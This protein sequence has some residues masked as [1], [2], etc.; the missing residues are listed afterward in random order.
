MP[1][2]SLR[3]FVAALERAGELRRIA[4]PVNVDL[5]ITEI[6]D[7][8]VKS[9][10]PA[11]LFENPVGP[12]GRAFDIPVLINAYAS[13]ARIVRALG[14]KSLDAVAE[15]VAEL[16]EIKPPEGIVAKLK[17]LPKLARM[18]SFSPKSVSSAACQE[19]VETEN[20]DLFAIPALKCWPEDGGRYITLPHVHS[21]NPRTGR[22]NVGMYRIQ[23]FDAKTAGMHMHLHHDGAQNFRESTKKGARLEMAVALGGDPVYAYAASA[24]LPPGIDEM[25]LAGFLRRTSVPLV[26]CKTVDVEVPADSDIVIEGY[27]DPGEL[28]REGP[29]GDHTGWYSLAD[30][31]PVFHVTAITRRRDAIYPTIIVGKPP[32]EDYWLGGAT[33]RIFL[34]LMKMQLPEIVDVHMPAEGV[35]HNM[36]I[37]SIRKSFPYHARKVMYALWGMGQMSLAKCIVIVDEDVDVHNVS[38]VAWKVLGSIDPRRD[39]VFV[40]GPVDALEHASPLP[41]V[42]SK[43]GVDGTRKWESEGFAREWPGE[44]VMSDEIRERVTQRWKEYGFD[45]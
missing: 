14:V 15:E 42:G 5:E 27:L 21:R 34:P 26:K 37:V 35:F 3:E 4:A 10:G 13:D 1:Y 6:A 43:L 8:C 19:I 20:I 40:D 38:E 44:L 24:P 2:A 45:A 16:L 33:G 36:V 18:A 22:R 31:Y 12:D 25:T 39:L 23:L 9:G 41:H 29:F 11:L 30:D 17:M 28:R 7:R 32:M